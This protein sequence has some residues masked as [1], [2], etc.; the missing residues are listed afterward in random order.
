MFNPLNI[1]NKNEKIKYRKSYST[2]AFMHN[3]VNVM[4]NK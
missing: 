2:K 4:N 1:L 3:A